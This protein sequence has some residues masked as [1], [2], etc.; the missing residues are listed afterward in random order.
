MIIGALVA[1]FTAYFVVNLGLNQ[2]VFGMG[3]YLLGLGVSS[4]LFLHYAGAAGTVPTVPTLPKLQIPFLSSIPYVG[5][6][7]TQ[8]VLVYV[9]LA[10]LL[11]VAF[12]LDKT[13]LGLKIRG[14]GQDPAVADSLGLNVQRYRFLGLLLSGTLGALGGLYIIICVTGLWID[15]I[16]AG[17]GFIVVGIIRVGSWTP[18][19]TLVACLLYSTVTGLQYSMQILSH[20]PPQL[21]QALPYMVVIFLLALPKPRER[22][23][24]GL[25]TPYKRE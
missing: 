14:V 22:M 16:T 9:S 7:F 24:K 19:K 4:V 8:N 1:A 3:I 17:A 5:R 11:V 21:F 23:P 13:W 20:L 6:L 25:G 2:V 18:W 15:N 12:I 10:V